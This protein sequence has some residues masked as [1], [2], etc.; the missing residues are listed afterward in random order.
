[1][2]WIN[3]VVTQYAN[4]QSIDQ[5]NLKQSIA[6]AYSYFVKLIYYR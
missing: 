5:R 2:Y 1:M 6:I 3:S 4:Y